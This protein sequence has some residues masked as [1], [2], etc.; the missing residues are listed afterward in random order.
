MQQYQYQLERGSTKH[1][2][3]SCH[4]KRF[5]R[6]VDIESGD[7]LPDVY[8]K[9][10]RETNCAYHVN[11]YKDGFSN[12]D[13]SLSDMIQIKPKAVKKPVQVFFPK[14]ILEKTRKDYHLNNFIKT[15]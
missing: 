6:Y 2:C 14:K 1:I 3:Q 12:N 15:Y 13:K 8:G 9:C 10:D 5:V 4:K 7:Y 11:P